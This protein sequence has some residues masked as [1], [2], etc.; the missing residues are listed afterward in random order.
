[1]T[2][3]EQRLRAAMTAVADATPIPPVPT[4]ASASAPSGQ[5]V[6]LRSRR[7]RGGWTAAGATVAVLATAAA[8]W[9]VLGPEQGAADVVCRFTESGYD[10]LYAIDA[11]SGDPVADC[12]VA[13]NRAYDTAVPALVAYNDGDGRVIVQPAER[14]ADDGWRALAPSARLDGRQVELESALADQVD[15][16]GAHCLDE[17]AA[18]RLAGA[19]LTRLGLSDWTVETDQRE[20]VADGRRVCGA[21]L[22]REPERRRVLLYAEERS[23]AQGPGSSLATRL[24]TSVSQACLSLAQA[25]D[26]VRKAA[27][28]EGLSEQESE[29]RVDAV[30]DPAAGCARVDLSAGGD[31]S[32]VVRGR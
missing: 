6:A 28:A 1:M 18:E 27:A 4:G 9:T 31:V 7:R 22:S 24:R 14:A 5:V 2:I 8:G 30:T 15:G 16:L 10:A 17:K 32:V 29:L 12:S 11:T 19:E 25:V 26:V 13:W 20:L 23:G 21:F 3:L